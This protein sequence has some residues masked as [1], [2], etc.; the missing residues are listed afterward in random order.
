[1]PF[2]LAWIARRTLRLRLPE[3][4]FTPNS[5]D[6]RWSR[7]GWTDAPGPTH[8][9]GKAIRSRGPA[10]LGQFEAA[11]ARLHWTVSNGSP[12]KNLT[13]VAMFRS[14]PWKSSMRLAR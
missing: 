3:I 2:D 12:L 1:M 10:V 9:K 14:L 6:A 4:V 8:N 13:K 11:Q 7:G 5:V